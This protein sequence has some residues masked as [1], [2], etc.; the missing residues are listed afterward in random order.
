MNITPLG[1]LAL[2][3]LI[4]AIGLNVTGCRS[5]RCD[6]SAT[7][8]EL[9]A[10]DWVSHSVKYPKSKLELTL[11]PTNV[12]VLSRTTDSVSN[13]RLGQFFERGA[14]MTTRFSLSPNDGGST[15]YDGYYRLADGVYLRESKKKKDHYAGLSFEWVEGR[16]R[17]TDSD[18]K[19]LRVY[20]GNNMEPLRETPFF[21][22]IRSGD[23]AYLRSLPNLEELADSNRNAL[24]RTALYQ[25]ARDGNDE[26]VSLLLEAGANV[27]LENDTRFARTPLAAAIRKSQRSTMTLLLDA[28]ANPNFQDT[29]LNTPLHIAAEG[30]GDYGEMVRMLL[31]AGADP[32]IA[33]KRGYT[34]QGRLERN[35]NSGFLPI[36]KRELK[37]HSESVAGM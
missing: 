1:H 6:D 21:A 16:L 23:V 11:I 36:L 26:I 2:F 19:M 32:S 29:A 5:L 7:V 27:D 8:R 24:G 3:T 22:A 25:A 13:R 28:G 20:S 31:A 17:V 35:K 18:E 34:A 14:M 30:C 10:G 9:P 33:N 4:S 15:V 37:R 12:E